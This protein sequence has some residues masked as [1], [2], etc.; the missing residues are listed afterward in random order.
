[1]TIAHIIDSLDA[2]GS[3][4]VAVNMVNAFVK[5][6]G[7]TVML[8]VGR[9]KGQLTDRISNE[10]HV[11]YLQKKS[12]LDA[13]AFHKL[14]RALKTNRVDIVHAHSTSFLW[15][16]FMKLF[17]PF[18]LLWHDHFGGEILPSGKRPT[19]YISF[20]T[21]FDYVFCV[22]RDLETNDKQW[23]KCN[24][25]N[26]RW[27]PNFVSKAKIPDS[28]TTPVRDRFILCLANFREQKDHLNLLNAMLLIR[29]NDYHIK[30]VMVGNVSDLAYFKKVND[31]IEN[32]H[33]NDQVEL[34]TT[35]NDPSIYLS[36]AFMGVLSSSSEGMPLALL[37]YGA[38]GLPVVC[39]SVGEIPNIMNEENGWLVPPNNPAILAM[40][41]Q[42]AWTNKILANKKATN[43]QQLVD[44]A[45]SEEAIMGEITTI[46]ESLRS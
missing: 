9:D 40:A 44:S 5:R 43:F 21:F 13:V 45:F 46:Y 26:I 23:L 3:E 19:W 36:S 31:F 18:K 7:F 8:I 33:L 6:S 2:G 37:E 15:P 32:E 4:T 38:Y 10:V 27:V 16:V 14:Y 17:L 11:V 22:S 20:S 41:I 28:S 25:E 12:M 34:V 1:M 30:L 29:K 39:T 42:E 24:P 35:C